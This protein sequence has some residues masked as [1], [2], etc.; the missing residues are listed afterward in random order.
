M[1][2]NQAA[3]A[4][5]VPSRLKAVAQRYTECDAAVVVEEG[6]MCKFHCTNPYVIF[7]FNEA[8]QMGSRK[9]SFCWE[10]IFICQ[11]AVHYAEAGAEAAEPS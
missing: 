4:V 8:I 11:G 2:Q 9:I 10:F 5:D 1:L 3:V 6:I 7:L